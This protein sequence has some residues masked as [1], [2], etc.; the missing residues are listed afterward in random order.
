MAQGSRRAPAALLRGVSPMLEEGWSLPKSLLLLIRGW[1]L[2]LAQLPRLGGT[3]W[4]LSTSRL[5]GCCGHAGLWEPAGP[6]SLAGGDF[7]FSLGN[8]SCI[9]AA[10]SDI[11]GGSRYPAPCPR[12]AAQPWVAGGAKIA[13]GSTHAEEKEMSWHGWGAAQLPAVPRCAA[14]G[15]YW[16]WGSCCKTLEASAASNHQ[17]CLFSPCIAVSV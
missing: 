8:G 10:S 16:C 7:F 2:N 3:H 4:G 15:Q 1:V 17:C 6:P 9:L 5:L 11:G 13:M 12:S 14:G